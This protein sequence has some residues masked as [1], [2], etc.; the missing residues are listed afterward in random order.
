MTQLCLPFPRRIPRHRSQSSRWLGSL[1]ILAL[2]WPGSA[3]AQIQR[4]AD[5]PEPLSAEESARRVRLPEGFRLE[6]IASEPLVRQP[7]GVCWDEQ[8]R[9]FVSELHGYNLEGQYDIDELNQTGQLDREV[10]RIQASPRAKEAALA[11]T[12]GVV[13]LLRDTDGDG[14]MDQAQVFA[15]GLPP[16]YGLCPAR[17]GLIVACA[18]DIIF[19]ADRDGDGRAEIRETLFTGFGVGA[20]E[21][22]INDPE[23]GLDDWIYFGR[24]H[25]GGEITGPRLPKPVRLGGT[26]FRIKA[27]G[28]AIE[29]VLGST[30]TFG[31]AFT[32]AGERFTI[33]TSRPGKIGRAHV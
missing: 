8:G 14:R 28:T 19:L 17:G 1:V 25:G 13:K 6:L 9:L 22:G 20:L 30:H 16:C 21:R 15:D 26:D 7:S 24:G 23:W 31:H 5:A 2:L 12:F 32:E 29:P 4:P 3:A 11:G 10:R 27:D 33:T 18:P